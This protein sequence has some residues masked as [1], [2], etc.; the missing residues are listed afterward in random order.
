M[1]KVKIG[2][3]YCEKVESGGGTQTQPDSTVGECQSLCRNKDT[4]LQNL[5]K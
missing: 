5:I 1:R 4:S 3:G 2:R